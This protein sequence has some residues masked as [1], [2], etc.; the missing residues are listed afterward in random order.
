M[1]SGWI[2]AAIARMALFKSSCY[3]MA[4]MNAHSYVD[5]QEAMP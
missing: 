5:Q 2:N 3:A 1:V 4:D